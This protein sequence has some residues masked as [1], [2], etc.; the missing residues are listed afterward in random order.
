MDLSGGDLNQSSINVLQKVEG[1]GKY[2]RDGYMCSTDTIKIQKLV[3]DE[4]KKIYPYI[5][6]EEDGIDGVKFNYNKLLDFILKM[7]KLD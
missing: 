3:H 5:V 2:G 6:I 1:M 7:F 4:I